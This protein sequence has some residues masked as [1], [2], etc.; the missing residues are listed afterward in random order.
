MIPIEVGRGDMEAA[1]REAPIN[2]RPL[3]TGKAFAAP[4]QESK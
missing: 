4:A 3:P 2:Q 1:G